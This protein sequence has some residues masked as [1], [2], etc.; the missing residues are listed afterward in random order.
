MRGSPREARKR[1]GAGEP[2]D[3]PEAVDLLG[4]EDRTAE[5]LG[6][7]HRHLAVV[8]LLHL[9]LLDYRE[10]H[11]RDGLLGRLRLLA[12]ARGDLVEEQLL[13]RVV[14]HRDERRVL[15]AERGERRGPVHRLGKELHVVRGEGE[16][17]AR[18][19]RI[20]LYLLIGEVFTF[21]YSALALYVAI[22]MGNYLLVP[23][24]AT[25]CVGFGMV[26]YWSFQERR[27]RGHS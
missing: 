12:E 11:L 14:I 25:V 6:H 1:S 4:D 9:R 5:R 10:E 3:V 13:E 27:A 16:Q 19:P 20:N 2:H 24:N 21:L 8:S 18:Q 22:R 17:A 26:L 23:L 15:L 7:R